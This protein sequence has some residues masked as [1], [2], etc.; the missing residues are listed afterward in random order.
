M[1]FPLLSLLAY[2]SPTTSFSLLHIT[3]VHLD[4]NPPCR[5]G[6]DSR[7]GTRTPHL[8]PGIGYDCDTSEVLLQSTLVAAADVAAAEEGAGAVVWSGDAVPHY[9]YDRVNETFV[10]STVDVVSRSLTSTLGGLKGW[11]FFP[12][13]GNHDVYPVFEW[14]PTSQGFLDQFA[15]LWRDRLPAR[16]D[17]AA[18]LNVTD[19][20]RTGAYYAAFVTSRTLMVTLNTGFYYDGNNATDLGDDPAGQFL[21]L[22]RVAELARRDG[23]SLLIHS[24]IAP[25]GGLAPRFAKRL[26][27]LLG[28]FADVITA[29]LF[30]HEHRDKFRVARG[31][32]C[33]LSPSVTPWHRPA[34][35]SLNGNNPAFRVYRG[36]ERDGHLVLHDFD[37]WWCNLTEAFDSGELEWKL[38]Y[39]W[40]EL[41]GGNVPLTAAAISDLIAG[42]LRTNAGGAFD[43][44]LARTD[45]FFPNTTC[46]ESCRREAMEELVCDSGL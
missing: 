19:T 43:D 44:Y 5:G 13:V 26:T 28:E 4:P 8:L 16:A 10:A 23:L 1:F 45:V 9:M 39:R 24:H 3:D 17:V 29:G 31:V 35:G 7:G 27:S 15:R 36:E 30:G 2:I 18:L 11:P 6:R 46:S 32:L 21:W 33:L 20:L 22:R 42:P 25:C 37:Q 34:W 12:A 14:S 40:S 38:E 41:Y